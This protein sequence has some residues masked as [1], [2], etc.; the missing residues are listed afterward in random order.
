MSSIKYLILFVLI[1]FISNCSTPEESKKKEV[2]IPDKITMLFVT[3]PNCPSCVKLEEVMQ[4][5]KP[6]NLI[7][8]Y[9][10]IKKVYLGE[11]LPAGLIPPNGTPTVY[12]L[13]SND[14]VLIEPII[15]EKDEVALMEFLEDAL[16][17]FKITY[18][19]DLR[20]LKKKEDTNETNISQT[21]A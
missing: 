15:G 1:F 20:K 2:I 13:G 4:Q 21:N 10:E 16:Y 9:F 12:F 5:E 18:G 8:N 3:Q 11:K 17:E 19:V 7:E 6:K 14:E